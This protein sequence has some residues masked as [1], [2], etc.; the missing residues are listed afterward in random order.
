MQRAMDSFDALLRRHRRMVLGGWAALI[1]AAVPFAAQQTDH[2]SSGGFG[3]PGSGSKTVSRELASF[4]GVSRDPLAVVL[5]P[6]VPSAHA[7]QTGLAR[8]EHALAG[9]QHVALTPAAKQRAL[10]QAGKPIVVVPLETTGS[11]EQTA[12]LAVDLRKDIGA[13]KAQ[14][15]VTVYMVGQEALWAGMQDVSKKQ[16]ADAER[17]GFPIVLLILLAVFGSL[18]AALL[19]LALGVASV[20]VTGAIVWWL[21]SHLGMSVFVT[22]LA[23]M[24]GIGVAVAYSLFVLARYREEIQ[25]GASRAAARATAMATSGTAVAFSGLTVIVSLGGLWMIDNQALRSMALGAML[26]VAV[27]VVASAT[28]LPVLI[29]LFGRRAY[30]RNRL[31]TIAGLALRSHARRRPGS[32]RPGAARLGFWRR[33]TNAIMRRP[34]VT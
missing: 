18:A 27:S 30:A 2:L 8:I 34:I 11:T 32:T 25:G 19:P 20:I 7:V 12:N 3:V 17:V 22:K 23:S 14:N 5:R 28:L 9:K 15:G 31:F 26:V 1:V 10:A 4:K 13:G 16:L 6:A 29:A 24:I 21:S 33:W